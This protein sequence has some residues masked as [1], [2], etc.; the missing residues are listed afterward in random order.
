MKNLRLLLERI[1]SGEKIKNFSLSLNDIRVL[2]DI[3]NDLKENKQAEFINANC[4]NILRS[5][6][7]L[8]VKEKG[9]GWVV[10]R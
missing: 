3:Y 5:C 2:Q 6:I 8:T 1:E 9:I 7:G 10:Y 4:Y